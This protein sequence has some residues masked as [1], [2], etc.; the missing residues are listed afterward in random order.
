MI[1][2]SEN[3]LGDIICS[4]YI[5]CAVFHRVE[6]VQGGVM[7]VLTYAIVCLNNFVN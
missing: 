6:S 7:N 5:S 1:M 3:Y 2:K 4:S